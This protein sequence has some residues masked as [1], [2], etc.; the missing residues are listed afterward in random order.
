MDVIAETELQEAGEWPSAHPFTVVA[1][2]VHLRPAR[3]G[4]GER[5]QGKIDTASDDVAPSPFKSSLLHEVTCI[6][7]SNGMGI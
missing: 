6:R 4:I 1:C 7:M 5:G 2:A 3:S